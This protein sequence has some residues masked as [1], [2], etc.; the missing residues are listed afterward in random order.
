M[1]DERRTRSRDP[2]DMRLLTLMLGAVVALLALSCGGSAERRETLDIPYPV[3]QAPGSRAAE[4]FALWLAEGG[5]RRL[6]LVASV[7]SR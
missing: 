6:Y 3:I 1:F 2:Q 4:A 7:V 5:A